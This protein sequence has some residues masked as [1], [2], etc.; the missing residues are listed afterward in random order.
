[1]NE[2]RGE[3]RKIASLRVP[4]K[5]ENVDTN[6]ELIPITQY[7]ETLKMLVQKRLELKETKQLNR[8][9]EVE[10][11]IAHKQANKKVE[12]SVLQPSIVHDESEDKK[13]QEMRAEAARAQESI[14]RLE[15]ELATTKTALEVATERAKKIESS[16]VSIMSNSNPNTGGSQE[17]LM[18]TATATSEIVTN[19][20]SNNELETEL[21]TTKEELSKAI[22]RVKNAESLLAIAGEANNNISSSKLPSAVAPEALAELSAD[23]IATND[24]NERLEAKLVATEQKLEEA[25]KR[26]KKAESLDTSLNNKTNITSGSNNREFDMDPAAAIHRANRLEVELVATKQKLEGVMK[27]A[28]KAE[29]LDDNKREENEDTE[30]DESSDDEESVVDSKDNEW[31]TKFNELREFRIVEGDCRVPYLTD[32][33]NPNFHLGRWVRNQ[34]VR[35]GKMESKKIAKLNHLGFWWGK[36]QPSPPSWDYNFEKLFAFNKNTGQCNIFIDRESPTPLAMWIS[37]QRTEYKRF[38]KSQ[39]SLLSI[40]QIQ[41]L[42]NIGL[43]W[44][45][46]KLRY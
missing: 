44:K 46:P 10:L 41:K 21:A 5:S 4:K 19:V 2:S 27:R 24:S 42:E 22:E 39:G 37:I 26:A 31:T 20:V 25:I 35:K 17:Q 1:M 9:L 6:D 13:K 7:R 11:S 40:D 3:K 38:K 32:I 29:S 30:G 45:G 43:N 33:Q 28:K 12:A 8:K 18:T 34:R 36:N 23:L 16:I 15:T 14:K